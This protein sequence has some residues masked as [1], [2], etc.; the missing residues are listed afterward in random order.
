[1]PNPTRNSG[2]QSQWPKQLG[3]A[4]KVQALSNSHYR[5]G[6]DCGC[7]ELNTPLIAYSAG[8]RTDDF[9]FI[10]ATMQGNKHV[11]GYGSLQRYDLVLSKSI[12]ARCFYVPWIAVHKDFQRR[13]IGTRLVAEIILSAKDWSEFLE[14]RPLALHA[15]ASIQGFYKQF[16]FELIGDSLMMLP[17]SVVCAD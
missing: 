5:H 11:L 12:G 13:G 2:K 4:C 1:M 15:K 16:G 7:D 6:F 3:P 14:P 10:A 9:R 8:H 17:A